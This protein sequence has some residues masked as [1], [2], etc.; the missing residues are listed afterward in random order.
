MKTNQEI[1]DHRTNL[2][3]QREGVRVGD[4]LKFSDGTYMRFS[5][6]LSKSIQTCGLDKGSF[7]FGDAGC[8]FS[9]TLNPP[10]DYKILKQINETKAGEVWFFNENEVK[11]H[12]GVYFNVDFRVFEIT[13]KA[14]EEKYRNTSWAERIKENA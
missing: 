10:I 1:L 12:N 11:A 6:R 4:F 5:Y 2:L 13:D 3:N 9:G 7:Y 8:L 14:V